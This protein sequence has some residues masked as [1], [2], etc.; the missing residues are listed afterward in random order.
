MVA[1]CQATC[2]HKA[3][4]RVSKEVSVFALK[5]E[6]SLQFSQ[7]YTTEPSSEPVEASTPCHSLS[8][9]SVK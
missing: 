9:L 5:S 6:E 3:T 8:I 2:F 7:N 1:L 4:V